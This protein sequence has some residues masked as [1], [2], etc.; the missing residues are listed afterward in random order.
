VKTILRE[1]LSVRW[2]VPTVSL[3]RFNPKKFCF[4]FLF[5]DLRAFNLT[6]NPDRRRNQIPPDAVPMGT[7]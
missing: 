5:N 1:K 7:V 4:R 2:G 3:M 6:T